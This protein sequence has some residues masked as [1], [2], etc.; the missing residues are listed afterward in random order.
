[1]Y[2]FTGAI[3]LS[4]EYLCPYLGLDYAVFTF[5]RPFKYSFSYLVKYLGIVWLDL[6][7]KQAKYRWS[8]YGQVRVSVNLCSR[9]L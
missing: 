1:M 9:L 7:A 6:L 2:S 3:I 8:L 5:T 4:I